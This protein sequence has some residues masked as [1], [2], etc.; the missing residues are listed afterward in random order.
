L[1]LI[2]VSPDGS[3]EFPTPPKGSSEILLDWLTEQIRTNVKADLMH[4]LFTGGMIEENRPRYMDRK[5]GEEKVPMAQR[6]SDKVRTRYGTGYYAGL[7]VRLGGSA[8]TWQDYRFFYVAAKEFGT[9]DGLTKEHYIRLAH[10]VENA[11]S[12]KGDKDKFYAKVGALLDQAENDG[13]TA[14]E[15]LELVEK[16]AGKPRVVKPD[17]PWEETVT[18][19]KDRVRDAVDAVGQLSRH[20]DAAIKLKDIDVDS[21]FELSELLDM[22][23]RD[24]EEWGSLAGRGDMKTARWPGNKRILLNNLIWQIKRYF[25]ADKIN[26]VCDVFGGRGH[27]ARAFKAAGWKTTVNDKFTFPHLWQL[28]VCQND[29]PPLNDE[30]LAFLLRETKPDLDKYGYVRRFLEP[31]FRP[32][33]KHPALSKMNAEIAMRVL[34]N[35]DANR[36]SVAKREAARA[37]LAAAHYDNVPYGQE[38]HGIPHAPKNYKL[39]AEM[40]K[41]L[42]YSNAYIF[43][44][45]KECWAVQEDA[46]EHL[47][48]H[49]YDLLYLDPP[50]CT[51]S[52]DSYY[53]PICTEALARGEDIKSADMKSPFSA[54]KEEASKALTELFK[55][56]DKS[57]PLWVF[58]YNESDKT[59]ISPEEIGRLITPWRAVILLKFAHRMSAGQKKGAVGKTVAAEY[60]FLCSP[61][62]PGAGGETSTYDRERIKSELHQET[63]EYTTDVGHWTTPGSFATEEEIKAYASK[64][65]YKYAWVVVDEKG[66][67][68]TVMEEPMGKDCRKHL[69]EIA[70]D[71]PRMEDMTWQLYRTA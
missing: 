3:Y 29:K 49:K 10:Y 22:F 27:V 2:T 12:F 66:N 9:R 35:A 65:I 24:Y 59:L 44:G 55:A 16:A 68:T 26:S 46:A 30:D 13:L 15:L 18:D 53:G 5:L 69:V 32:G 23:A 25:K 1:P 20:P 50:Y 60:L 56:A 70:N 19:F 41:E 58:S 14:R 38:D 62:P 31:G 64:D 54:G 8:R 37:L 43:K 47:R 67:R 36:F 57:A 34:T 17:R 28:L 4:Q 7:A 39:D 51:K 52:A 33:A 63:N 71:E 40:R 48:K 6:S 61:Y 42:K 21:A 11:D 45:R